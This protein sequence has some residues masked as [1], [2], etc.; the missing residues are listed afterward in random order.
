MSAWCYLETGVSIAV[1]RQVSARDAF[2]IA[3]RLE[4]VYLPGALVAV[5]AS[6][7]AVVRR[8]RRR[9]AAPRRVTRG[10][11]RGVEPD[12]RCLPGDDSGLLRDLTPDAVGPLARAAGVVFSVALLVSARGLARRRHR[13]WQVAVTVAALSASLHA[14]GGFNH[15]TLA[16]AVIL[17]LL[18]ARRHDFDGPG[19][20]STRR[21][22]VSRTIISIASIAGYGMAA[23]WLNRIDADQPFTARFAGNEI[24]RGLLGLHVHG[25]PHLSGGFSDWYPLSLV[26]LGSLATVWILAGWLAPWRHRVRQEQHERELARALVHASGADTLAPFVLRADK[27]YFFTEDEAAFLAYRV[28]GGVAIVSGDPIGIPSTSPRSCSG[29]SRTRMR[30]TGAL[31]FSAR[32][33]GGFRSTPRTGCTPCTTATKRS[34]T[35]TPSRWKGAASAR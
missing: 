10:R 13:A 12:A 6:A 3:A 25:S 1:V 22:V 5:A 19:D 35:S 26:L 14:L 24:A 9:P 17:T 2:D 33:S 16:S 29:S 28:V 20:T 30:E 8:S 27:A 23:L 31:R 11:R 34:S 15:G 7:L 18:L 32:R 4:A 21:L